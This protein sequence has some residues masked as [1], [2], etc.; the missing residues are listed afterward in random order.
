[1]DWTNPRVRK[2]AE[3]EE[4]EMS[5][6]VSGF[7]ARMRKRAASAQGETSLGSEVLGGKRPKLSSPNKEAQKSPTVINV[8][9]SD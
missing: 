6:L 2:L 3:E 9:S 1:M 7:V 4:V 8:D 5:G